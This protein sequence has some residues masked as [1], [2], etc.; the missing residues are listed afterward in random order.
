MKKGYGLAKQLDEAQAEFTELQDELAQAREGLRA[1]ASAIKLLQE[2]VMA[3]AAAR[4]IP[5]LP[6]PI[7]TC[8]GVMAIKLKTLPQIFVGGELQPAQVP[9]SRCPSCREQLVAVHF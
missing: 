6:C 7:S 5:L 8:D 3:I 1:P 4:S 2:R 9:P